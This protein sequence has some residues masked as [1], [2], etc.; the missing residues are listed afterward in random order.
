MKQF[1]S[2]LLAYQWLINNNAGECTVVVH[3]DPYLWTPAGKFTETWAKGFHLERQYS[4]SFYMHARP[5][6]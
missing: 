5:V 6:Y 1:G 4:D 3:S 2:L